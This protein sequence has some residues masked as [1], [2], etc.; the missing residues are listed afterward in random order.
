MLERKVHQAGEPEKETQE[1]VIATQTTR[2]GLNTSG[3]ILDA[4]A[5]SVRQIYRTSYRMWAMRLLRGMRRRRPG[6]KRGRR[7]WRRVGV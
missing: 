5:P 3:Y 4:G 7:C 6:G 1:E 2:G